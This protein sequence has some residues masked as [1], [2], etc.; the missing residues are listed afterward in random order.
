MPCTAV[1]APVIIETLLVFEKAGMAHF[2]VAAKAVCTKLAIFGSVPFETP[3][4][5]Y[6]GSKP[7]TQMTTVGRSGS[8]YVLQCSSKLDRDSA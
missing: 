5:R 1:G 8:L 6:S 2:G 4:S 3:C 7:S